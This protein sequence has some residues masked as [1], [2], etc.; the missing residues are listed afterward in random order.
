MRLAKNRW[1]IP[2]SGAVLAALAI[3]AA[4]TA[5][6]SCTGTSTLVCESGVRCREGQECAA[7]QPICIPAGGCGNGIQGPRE[8]CDDGN[9]QSGDGCSSDCKFEICGNG[10]KD[11]H[12]ECDGTPLCSSDC[13]L[14]TCGNGIVDHDADEECDD[15]GMDTVG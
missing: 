15:G 5:S 4:G 2:T 7:A 12:E 11:V 3:A 8:E 9:I 14:Q 6:G 10:I 13:R 1:W